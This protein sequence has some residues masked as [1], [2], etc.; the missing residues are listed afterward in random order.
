MIILYR[1]SFIIHFTGDCS[2]DGKAVV[3]WLWDSQPIAPQPKEITG[4]E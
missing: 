3:K 2:K 1:L 4:L